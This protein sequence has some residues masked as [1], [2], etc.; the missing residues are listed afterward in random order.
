MPRNPNK[1]R[2]K[3]ESAVSIGLFLGTMYVGL[4]GLVVEHQGRIVIRNLPYVHGV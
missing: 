1:K 2:C 3:V 4:M